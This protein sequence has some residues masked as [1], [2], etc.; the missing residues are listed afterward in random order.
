MDDQTPRE[1]KS[2]S[3]TGADAALDDNL[4]QSEVG[5]LVA[6]S[7]FL[8]GSW[9]FV[10]LVIGFVGNLALAR[11]LTPED[12]GLVAI[13]ATVLLVGTAIGDAGLGAGLI[14]QT[15]PPTERQLSELLGLQLVFTTVLTA[16]GCLV[17]LRFGEDGLVTA[18]V[19]LALPVTALQT[20]GRAILSRRLDFARITALDAAGQIALYAW[21]IP[22]VL[23]GMGVWGMATGY[24]AK[25]IAGTAILPLVTNLRILRPALARPR[26]HGE[27]LWFGLRFQASW[28][29]IVGRDLIL[30]LATAAIAGVA[31]L[32]LWSLARRLME[33]PLVLF[34][35]LWRVLFPSMT[36]ILETGGA[37]APIVERGVRVISV[38][39]ALAL[40]A[41]AGAVPAVVPG[42]F[43]ESW[44]EVSEVIPWAS[45]G[46][47]ISGG[48]AIATAGY[49]SA[50]GHPGKNFLSAVAFAVTW[51]GSTAVLLPSLG[52]VAVGIGWIVG[53]LAE[54]AVLAAAARRASG[55][56]V[57]RNATV[58]LTAGAAGC[59]LGGL[60]SVELDPGVTSAVLG[61]AIAVG[62]TALLLALAARSSLTE[63]A[64]LVRTAWSRS[65]SPRAA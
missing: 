52:A 45:V 55:A 26:K 49:L 22:A 43:G 35:A 21:S 8:T 30:N 1:P 5:D 54:S 62:T 32:G 23:L 24:V 25:A 53:A 2:S 28:F 41:F 50:A 65:R 11:L 31:T 3:S 13:G 47:M 17:A 10:S 18:V 6:R 7:I 16:L 58:P 15:S 9:G 33:V 59:L 44:S 29:V 37:A 64:S 39:S 34:N 63:S 51:I 48:I 60:T 46:L 56:R 57:I 36:R 27:L 61:F 12:F 42:L 38:V 4:T 40:S 20:T 19:L 14:R